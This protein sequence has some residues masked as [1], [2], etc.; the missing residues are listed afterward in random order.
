MY[1]V[2]RVLALFLIFFT[3]TYVT[4]EW[5]EVS[6]DNEMTVYVET[7]LIIPYLKNRK[8]AKELHEYRKARNDGATSLR[9]RTDYDCKKRMVRILAIDRVAGEMGVGK[10]ISL[11]DKPSKWEK[12][13]GNNRNKVL[14]YVC[15]DR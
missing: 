6:A 3:S 1:I 12:V 9:I 14:D 2:V 10:I 11:S 7:D 5:R 13:K 15:K 8:M 4:A